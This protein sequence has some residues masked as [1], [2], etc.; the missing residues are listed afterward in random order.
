MKFNP[1]IV[2]AGQV[3]FIL[4]ALVFFLFSNI[5]SLSAANLHLI[6]VA[7]TTD[8]SIGKSVEIDA[9]RV[10]TVVKGIASKTGLRL[11][12]TEVSGKR[13]VSTNVI[14]AVNNAAVK[15]GD[16]V[17]FHYSG[18]GYRVADKKDRWPALYMHDE[19]GV[20]ML[21]VAKTLAGK[22][23]R[24]LIVLSDS[25][26]N[27]I[28][29]AHAPPMRNS[30]FRRSVPEAYKR[31]FLEY[32][33]VILGSGSKPGQYSMGDNVNGGLFTNQFILSLNNQLK[34]KDADWVPL[35]KTAT[36]PIEVSGQTSGNTQDPQ[37][38]MKKTRGNVTEK[39]LPK[40]NSIVIADGGDDVPS[41]PDS[42]DDGGG[43]VDGGG[44]DDGTG[45]DDGDDTGWDD[46]DDFDDDS[47]REDDDGF[48]DGWDDDVIIGE[49]GNPIDEGEF[50]DEFED[51]DEF[52]CDDLKYVLNIINKTSS[53]ISRTGKLNTSTQNYK[54]FKEIVEIYY[55][56]AV[57]V[58]DKEFIEDMKLLKS[59]IKNK[60][61][62][63]LNDDF[64]KPFIEEL[65][66]EQDEFCSTN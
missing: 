49:D 50:D 37:F 47:G 32:K 40:N 52:Y 62:Q 22:N 14:N 36:R 3:K 29:S 57:E 48:D 44:I 65:K 17:Y 66:I 28:D 63:E 56:S 45:W 61:Y 53:E 26:N 24:F 31:L 54:D 2:R 12:V 25:C 60:K 19:K 58:D 9:N 35:M 7:D 46:D 38:Y 11:K 16:V 30:S 59:L 10:K 8:S 43:I 18:H 41:E 64:L 15:K 33:G 13:M 51:E 4:S 39:D 20:D 27:V 1:S 23:P 34:N 6:L 42:P 55:E 21:W 5:V